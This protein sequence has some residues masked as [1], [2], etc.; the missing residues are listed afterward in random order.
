MAFL[1]GLPI[2]IGSCADDISEQ[3]VKMEPKFFFFAFLIAE[4]LGILERKFE[5]YAASLN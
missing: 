3:V 4:G 1:S 2:L 5:Y